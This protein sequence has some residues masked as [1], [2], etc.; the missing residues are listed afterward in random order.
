MICVSSRQIAS[1]GSMDDALCCRGSSCAATDCNYTPARR[2]GADPQRGK[3]A[4]L[5][6]NGLENS[7]T[8]YCRSKQRKIQ[9]E[10]ESVQSELI[11]LKTCFLPQRA[12]SRLVWCAFIWIFLSFM[13]QPECKIYFSE[14][15]AAFLSTSVSKEMPRTEVENRRWMV[16][17]KEPG[18]TWKFKKKKKKRI[19]DEW[20]QDA[21]KACVGR[22]GLCLAALSC[23]LFFFIS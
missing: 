20:L 6:L 4:T 8:L 18:L 12:S 17:E 22:W 14:L 9:L 16:S 21:W 10:T 7:P 19:Q 2:A 13:F 3:W 15:S 23:A 5:L 1:K 11:D